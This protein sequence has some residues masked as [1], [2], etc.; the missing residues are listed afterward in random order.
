LTDAAIGYRQGC[1]AATAS[2]GML[3]EHAATIIAATDKPGRCRRNR[4]RSSQ[5]SLTGRAPLPHPQSPSKSVIARSILLHR[6]L[7]HRNGWHF[8]CLLVNWPMVAG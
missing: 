4:R 2:C 7:P 3:P 1:A 5:S 8:Y 6:Q